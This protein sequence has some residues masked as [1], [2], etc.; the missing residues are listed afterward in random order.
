MPSE[1]SISKLNGSN[2]YKWK[3]LM[4]ALLVRR[5][6]MEYVDGSKAK[7]VGSP[8]S[9][10]VKDFMK[11]LAEARAEIILH[12]EVSQLAHVRDPDPTSIW[13]TL[14]TIHCAHGFATHLML[15]HKFLMLHKSDEMS[16][17][18]WVAEVHHITFQLQEVGI[19]VSDEDII[20]ALTLSLPPSYELFNISLNT[21][22]PDQF[23]LDYVIACLTDEEAR[24]QHGC[25]TA[26]DS[27]D[28]SVLATRAQRWNQTPLMN[29]TC[30]YCGEKGH[31]QC[32]CPKNSS[33]AGNSTSRTDNNITSEAN[34]VF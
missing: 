22:P 10:A 26:A 2:Y 28:P 16:I 34:Y 33:G 9:K 21:T 6:L 4:E 8:N 12:V 5:G 1:S 15:R 27:P 29:I 20:L 7:P 31:Y 17:Q 25:D 3:M 19:D 32:D 30:F 14:E 11:R 24:Q 18:A 13:S 23:T